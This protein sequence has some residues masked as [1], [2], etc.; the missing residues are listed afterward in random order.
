MRT[1]E[2]TVYKFDELSDSAKEKAREWYR[3]GQF[4]DS[5]WSEYTIE[6]A[7]REGE[8]LGISFKERRIPL[9][10]GKTRGEACI[11]WSGFCSQGDGACFEGTWNASDV[12]ADKV[13]DGWGDDP[14]TTEIKRIA[15]VFAEIA[16]KFPCSS[17]TVVHR[18]H[19]SHENCTGFSFDSGADYCDPD[20]L[21]RYRT[22]DDDPEDPDSMPRD[23]MAEDFPE[24]LLE[25]TAKDFMRWIYRQ[26]EKEYSYQTSDEAVDESIIANEYEFNKNGGIE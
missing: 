14:A 1:K 5:S 4:N 26:L 8:L 11:W 19:Y 6:E 16:K 22:P 18:G 2:T 25:E 20:A 17:F 24:D 15:S 10:N 3:R 7:V 12:K 9:M 21:V 13:A 23:R